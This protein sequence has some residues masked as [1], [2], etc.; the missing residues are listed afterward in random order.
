[1][2]EKMGLQNG[3][4]NEADKRRKKKKNRSQVM[5]ANVEVAINSPMW[6]SW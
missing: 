5:V 2:K 4:E 3:E 1:M 6:R